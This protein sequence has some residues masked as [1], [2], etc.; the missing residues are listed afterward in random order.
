MAS[1]GVPQ[2]I[3]QGFQ[4]PFKLDTLARCPAGTLGEELHALIVDNGLDR[5]VLERKAL[6]VDLL[7]QRHD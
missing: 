6:G 1:R 7:Q 4:T 2:A 3:A 5:E